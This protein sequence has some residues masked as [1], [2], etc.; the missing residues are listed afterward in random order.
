[1]QY[2]IETAPGRV[3]VTFEKAPPDRTRQ[4]MNALGYRYSAMHKCWIGKKNAELLQEIL[5]YRAEEAERLAQNLKKSSSTICWDCANVYHDKCPWHCKEPKPVDGW[6]AVYNASNDSYSV[7]DCPNF[8]KEERRKPK[9]G[10]H[11][12]TDNTISEEH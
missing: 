2:K 6:N 9:Y 1:M 11:Q 10:Y 4:L 7:I 3:C 8:E 5:E 12:F